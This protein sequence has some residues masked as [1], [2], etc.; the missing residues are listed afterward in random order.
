MTLPTCD[1][2]E[3][4]LSIILCRAVRAAKFYNGI[5]IIREDV[6]ELICLALAIALMT[7]SRVCKFRGRTCPL[8]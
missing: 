2:K 7:L 1:T 5:F 8:W 3:A 4:L 6:R